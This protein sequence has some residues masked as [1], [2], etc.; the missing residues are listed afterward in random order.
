MQ[1]EQLLSEL[2]GTSEFSILLYTLVGEKL[3]PTYKGV[4]AK[5]ISQ[6]CVTFVDLWRHIQGKK[7]AVAVLWTAEKLQHLEITWKGAFYSRAAYTI[8]RKHLRG[9]LLEILIKSL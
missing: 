1:K 3:P 5:K 8:S 9:V 7:E 6:D 4:A 2:L